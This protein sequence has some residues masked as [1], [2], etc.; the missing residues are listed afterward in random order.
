MN[1]FDI[2]GEIQAIL[3]LIVTRFL[4]CHVYAITLEGNHQSL[5]NTTVLL[6]F[7]FTY[8]GAFT[9]LLFF[10]MI[11][12]RVNIM[13][14]SVY[15]FMAF[16]SVTLSSFAVGYFLVA[17][18]NFI[19]VTKFEKL[20]FMHVAEL[21]FSA[22]VVIVSTRF[23]FRILN[24]NPVDTEK[25]VNTIDVK[26]ILHWGLTLGV[27]LV[28]FRGREIP[29]P[30]IALSL[31]LEA[32]RSVLSYLFNVKKLI[33]EKIST[34]NKIL[35]SDGSEVHQL[36]LTND[37][38]RE[39]LKKTTQFTEKE[40]KNF[41][42]ESLTKNNF[43]NTGQYQFK[44]VEWVWKVEFSNINILNVLNFIQMIVISVL[45][46]VTVTPTI[47]LR[48]SIT[49]SGTDSS[50]NETLYRV[51]V[52]SNETTTTYG[53][54]SPSNFIISS[55]ITILGVLFVSIFNSFIYKDG[56]HI[57]HELLMVK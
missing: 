17:I 18:D 51:Q 46:F 34:S 28:L 44:P 56:V 2:Y 11:A 53:E 30:F 20:N 33:W 38:L 50:R 13:Q 19:F 27:S 14:A 4:V 35:N 57:I 21:T 16:M 52:E 26:T 29:I 8:A 41:G 43:V 49:I 15:R 55:S 47:S 25:Y 39:T 48:N 54:K 12:L 23:F 1:V 5:C 45:F 42:I 31:S 37:A 7:I 36:E 40:W 10:F 9:V 22:F 6:F 24:F 3:F 32:V